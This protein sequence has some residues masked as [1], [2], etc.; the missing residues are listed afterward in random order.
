MSY[1]PAEHTIDE[2]HEYLADNPDETAAV[3]VAE[4]ARGDQARSTLVAS[5]EGQSQGE[6]GVA[7][8]KQ[9][10][11]TLPVE[12]GEDLTAGYPHGE[13]PE[14]GITGYIVAPG[15]LDVFE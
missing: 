13:Y 2:V 11:D 9:E 10:P 3:L 8:D 14:E 4:R 7:T 12:E 5:L 15:R 6:P 1:D